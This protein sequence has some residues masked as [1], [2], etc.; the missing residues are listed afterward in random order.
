MLCART[1]SIAPVSRNDPMTTCVAPTTCPSRMTV[2]WLKRG[3]RRH[4]QPLEGVET[5]FARV[6][7]L[8]QRVQIVGQQNGRRFADPVDARFSRGIFERDDEDALG[9]AAQAAA[10]TRTRN[11]ERRNQNPAP[12]TRNLEPHFIIISAPAAQFTAM[13]Q[14][15]S[16]TP[17]Q[18]CT[19]TSP[20]TPT[21]AN[22]CE[23]AAE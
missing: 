17:W 4:L 14:V 19:R 1:D 10:R 22:R 6:R 12:R 16:P 3:D 13:T 21:S 20:L 23:S 11:R 7:V 5:L 8:A 18:E 2:A 9:G 15:A